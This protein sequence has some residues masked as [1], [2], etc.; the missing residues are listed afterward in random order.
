MYFLGSDLMV[1]IFSEK[2]TALHPITFRLKYEFVDTRLGGEQWNGKKTDEFA[3]SPCV[4][5]FR[6]KKKGTI[7][8]PRNV[9][10]FGKGGAK[11][12]SCIYRIEGSPSERV[13]LTIV[14][15]SF[16]DNSCYTSTDPHT[17]R[18]KCVRESD[19][20]RTAELSVSEAPWKNIV[21]PHSC[22][23]DNSTNDRP[24]LLE[25]S[26]RA[27]EIYF[28]V[29]KFNTTDDFINL[30]FNAK[31]ELVKSPECTRRQKVGGSGGEFAFSYPPSTSTEI[32]CYGLPWLVEGY[33]NMSLFLLT[34]GTFMEFD[35]S[36]EEISKCPTK[37]RIL[38]YS[39]KPTRYEFIYFLMIVN[40]LI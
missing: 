21:I 23:C 5:I 8:S 18:P 4:R 26:S 22:F 40:F 35:A 34:W 31:F 38:I 7:R 13:K 16:G 39:G 25:F 1:Q 14:N 12:L 27:I 19:S 17:G 36:S 11:N 30:Y 2:G 6:R 33:Q 3:N 32:N 20:D 29:S 9:F 24:L 28:K 10:F 15:A 37:N